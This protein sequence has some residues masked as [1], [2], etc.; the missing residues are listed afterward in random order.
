MFIS[1][2][3]KYGQQ[4]ERSSK[5]VGNSEKIINIFLAHIVAEKRLIAPRW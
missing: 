3:P 5:M 1:L 2:R 4:P